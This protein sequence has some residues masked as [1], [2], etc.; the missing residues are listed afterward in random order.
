MEI[1]P[2]SINVNEN[3][4]LNSNSE[5]EIFYCPFCGAVKEYIVDDN[6]SDLLN[7]NNLN[8]TELKIIDHAMKLEIFNG[9]FYKQASE[10]AS[11][12][13]IKNMFAALSRIEY[14]HARIHQKLCGY[15]KLTQLQKID[16]A[17]YEGEME[18]LEQAKLREKHAVDYYNKY[19][20]A[21]ENLNVKVILKELKRVEEEHILLIEK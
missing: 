3:A 5:G 1:S 4:F 18:L 8:E 12:I 19:E 17:R 2:K 15:N 21:I 6:K 9:D 13:K 10:L 14:T 16:Y 20:A 7:N 11:S